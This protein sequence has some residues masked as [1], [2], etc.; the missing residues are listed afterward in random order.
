MTA[1][2][3][4]EEVRV[5]ISVVNHTDTT[6]SDEEVQAS[7]R[8]INRQLQEDYRSAWGIDATLRLEGRGGLQPDQQVAASMRGDAVIYLWEGSDVPGA[9]GY[10][11]RN[12]R[13]IPYGFVF[14]QLSAQLGE[15]WSVTL[16]HEALELV[17][18]PYVNQLVMGPHPADASRDVFF[19]YEMCDAVQAETYEIDGVAVSNFL[20][21]LYFTVEA[22]AEGRNDF[23]G[24]LHAG[25]SLQSFGL[26]PGGYIGFWD[27]TTGQHETYAQRDDAKAAERLRIKAQAGEARRV[28]RYQKLDPAA[29]RS[30]AQSAALSNGNLTPAAVESIGA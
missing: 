25:Q 16:S 20:L 26:N 8:A 17:G 5:L 24:R 4:G 19:W 3:P 30:E 14:T 9:L 23:L 10:H 7:V 15:P 27:P 1:R 18:D 12:N 13:G 28:V 21:P 11:D 29:R 2:L 22:E 6:I